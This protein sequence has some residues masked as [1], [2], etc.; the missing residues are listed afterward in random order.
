MESLEIRDLKAIIAGIAAIMVEKKDELITL[1]GAMGD[2][3]LGLTMEK[4]FTTAGK[5]PR[6]SEEADAR[7]VPREARHGHRR[8]RRPRPWA[9]SLPRASCPAEGGDRPAALGLKETAAF[10]EAFVAGIMQRGKSKPG[11]KTL[12]DVLYPAAQALS[13]AAAAGAGMKEAFRACRAAAAE[14]LAKTGR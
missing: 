11:E 2:G 6:N 4:A 3:D 8:A 5:R 1:D 10:F 13:A 9:R 7:Q 14:G 12:V